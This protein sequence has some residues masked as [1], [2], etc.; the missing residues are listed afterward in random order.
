R[1]SRSNL[2]DEHDLRLADFAWVPRGLRRVPAT[3][4]RTAARCIGDDRCADRNQRNTADCDDSDYSQQHSDDPHDQ[5]FHGHSTC[6]NIT[7]PDSHDHRFWG[8]D[9]DSARATLHTSVPAL[10]FVNHW[11]LEPGCRRDAI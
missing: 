8:N 6:R 10:A 4:L 5:P 11:S 7:R 9:I 2:L 1:L 3:P